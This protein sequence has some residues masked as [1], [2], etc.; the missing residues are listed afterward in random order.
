MIGSR[1]AR[2]GDHTTIVIEAPGSQDD[3]YEFYRM[4]L[5]AAGWQF[6]GAPVERDPSQDRNEAGGQDAGREDDPHRQDAYLLTESG[7][8]V[9]IHTESVRPGTTEVWIE[10]GLVP[11]KCRRGC[12][13]L[14]A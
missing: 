7:P 12:P 1:V 3:L 5:L 2:A 13:G 6:A 8:A 4:Q 10:V 11:L 9:R 14:S